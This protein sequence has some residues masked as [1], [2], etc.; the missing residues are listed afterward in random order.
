VGNVWEAMKKNQAE[1]PQAPKEA[2]APVAQSAPATASARVA[3]MTAPAAAPSSSPAGKAAAP[4]TIDSPGGPLS[5]LASG[6][7]YADVLVAHHDRGG[8]ITE[9]YRSLRTHLLAQHADGRFCIMVT[10]AEAGE[11]KSVTT[12]NLAVTLAER[13]ERSTVIVDGDIRR[14][15]V[16]EI[17]SGR[18]SPGLADVLRGQKAI[19]DVLQPTKY[20]NLSFVSCGLARRDEAADLVGRPELGEAIN[21]LHRQFDYVLLD[22]PPVNA[23]SDACIM[24]GAV[25]EAIMVMRMN[26][27][28]RDSA[29]R[30][31][32]LLKASNVKVIGMVLTHQKYYIPNYLYRYS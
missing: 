16:A 6:N 11:G 1:Q 26:R 32:R 20:A 17:F 8:R 31:I 14:G 13:R 2:E 25:G 7:G 9:Q 28:S 18:K 27:T 19:K 24:A 30:A 3:A 4:A 15:R 10:S 5:H 21:A 23:I 12:A 29:D 22:S